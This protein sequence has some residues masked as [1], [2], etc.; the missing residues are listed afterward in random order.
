MDG[1][2]G[3]PNG[4]FPLVCTV[5]SDVLGKL[6]QEYIHLPCE[7]RRAEV[8]CGGHFPTPIKRQEAQS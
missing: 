1:A 6:P 5:Q 7:T 3:A 8:R 2:F 4:P